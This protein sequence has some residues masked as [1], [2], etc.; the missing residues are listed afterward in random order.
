MKKTLSVLL[1]LI[2][3]FSLA[4]PASAAYI[5]GQ[6]S[7]IPIVEI[8]GDGEPLYDAQGNQIFK[9]TDI[10]SGILGDDEDAEEGDSNP[11]CFRC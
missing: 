6:G 1:A 3:I 2:M 8:S 10:L 7:Q 9:T 11:I 5:S 4:M